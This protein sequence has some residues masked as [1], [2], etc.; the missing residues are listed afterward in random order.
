[1][2]PCNC[3][4]K[5]AASADAK[6]RVQGTGDPNVDKVYD[7]KTAAEMALATSGKTGTVKPA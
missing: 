3:G 6:Y 5:A 7:S 2:P 4:N 1:M